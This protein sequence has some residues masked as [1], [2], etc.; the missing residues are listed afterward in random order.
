MVR[1][2]IPDGQGHTVGLTQTLGGTHSA[3]GVGWHADPMFFLVNFEKRIQTIINL[4]L[5][6]FYRANGDLAEGHLQGAVQ[7]VLGP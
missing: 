2:D 3:M 5:G 6:T 1:C 4:Q 7:S